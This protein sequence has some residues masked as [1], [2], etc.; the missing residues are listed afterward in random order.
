MIQIKYNSTKFYTG[1]D[2]YETAS[3]NSIYNSF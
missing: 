1:E 2:S 3:S